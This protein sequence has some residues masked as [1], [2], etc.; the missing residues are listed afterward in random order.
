MPR[1]P[2]IGYS[3]WAGVEVTTKNLGTES[4]RLEIEKALQECDRALAGSPRDKDV[5][6]R[7]AA[8]LLGPY[9]GALY[10][11]V[12]F[13]DTLRDVDPTTSLLRE[14][15]QFND[16]ADEVIEIFDALLEIDPDHLKALW[17]RGALAVAFKQW[18]D[19][20]HYFDRMLQLDPD[21]GETWSAKGWCLHCLGDD[22]AALESYDRALERTPS[23]D[24][25]MDKVEALI[26]LG[27][28]REALDTCNRIDARPCLP[29]DS[30]MKGY[31]HALLGEYRE[32]LEQMNDALGG[33]FPPD[34]STPRFID[35]RAELLR[36]YLAYKTGDML[37]AEQE[38]TDLK[39]SFP[40]NL[41]GYLI[42]GHWSS[43]SVDGKF[44][45]WV[46]DLWKLPCDPAYRELVGRIDALFPND[47]YGDDAAPDRGG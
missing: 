46:T 38:L 26:E 4:L 3:L 2:S 36:P 33:P 17:W 9:C 25:V 35:D 14:W 27:R 30:F 20:I 37:G 13:K 24:V 6:L 15:L 41:V 40:R 21:D 43:A 31:I 44:A 23:D 10:L 22:L 1:D 34:K 19:G 12:P 47:V 29:S 8:I 39:N 45:T 32:A 16:R 42:S 7:K 18:K 5:L 28:L 11:M